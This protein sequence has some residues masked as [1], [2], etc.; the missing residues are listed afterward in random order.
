A[1][2]RGLFSGP[3]Q[4]PRVRAAL[5][6]DAQ[7]VGLR[8]LYERLEQIDPAA[9]S[10]IHPNDR[11]R[12]IRALEVYELTG[13]PMSEWQRRHG[14]GEVPF[15]TLKIG[16]DRHRAELYDL[17]NQRCD[18]MIEAGFVDEVRSLLQVGYSLDLKPMRSV[19]Y[20]QLASFLMGRLSLEEAVFMIKR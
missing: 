11:Q 17:I 15:I 8:S 19:G 10:W 20:K 16:L 12:I 6:R 5:A 2:T 3:A 4:D 9:R 14:F 18:Q 13:K 7:G 1:L